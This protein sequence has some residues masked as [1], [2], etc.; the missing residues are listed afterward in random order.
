MLSYWIGINNPLPFYLLC[1]IVLI[2]A[3]IVFC[4]GAIYSYRVGF[5]RNIIENIVDFIGDCGA[6][7]R[8]SDWLHYAAHLFIENKRQTIEALTRSQII[9]SELREPDYLAQEDCVYGKIGNTEIFFAEVF[10][11]NRRGWSFR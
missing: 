2:P 1:A 4:K 8:H 3:W 7:H 11:E 10:A 6:S 9:R 5:K